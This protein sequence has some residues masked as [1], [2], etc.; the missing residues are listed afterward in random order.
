[1][2]H[3]VL[4]TA[5]GLIVVTGAVGLLATILNQWIFGRP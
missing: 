5:G 3:E 1:M 2:I 4:W